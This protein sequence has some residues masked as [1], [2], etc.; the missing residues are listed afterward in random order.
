VRR[1]PVYLDLAVVLAALWLSPG[2][3]QAEP[4][5]EAKRGAKGEAATQGAVVKPLPLPGL[6]ALALPDAGDGSSPRLAKVGEGLA[7]AWIS[8][9]GTP[10]LSLATLPF[11]EVE[12]GWGEPQVVAASS[13]LLVNWADVA[14]IGE[15][16][17]GRTVVAWPEYH[18]DD[19]KAGYGLRVA[20]Q[21]DDGSFAPAWSPDDV[22]RGPESGFVGFIA[23]PAGLRMFW[24]DGRELVGHGHGG[25]G[26]GGG[27]MQLRSVLLDDDG[28]ALGGSAILDDRTCECCKLGVGLL[29]EQP[30]AAYRD[31]SAA[32]VRDIFVAGPG[33]A[34]TAVANDGWTIAGCP[35]N[36]PAVASD[37]A[38]AYVAWFTGADDRS[39]TWIARASTPTT[40]EAPTRFDLGLPAGRVD[41]L[42]LADGGAL[43]TWF[44]YDAEAP[45][46]ALLLTRRLG[47][48][49]QLGPAFAVAEVGAAR[50]WGFPRTAMVGDE[51]L[52]VVTDPTPASGRPRLQGLLGPLPKL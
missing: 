50:D 46:R 42:A 27:T 49:G 47:S 9:A 16:A 10:T 52:W 12:A 11:A 31:R 26:D 13:R 4:E 21:L 37:G 44:E 17:A 32:E 36:G 30:F 29:G 24:L 19:P 15:T 2:C 48:E 45:G 39:A 22:Q 35:V 51:A 25:H 41:L 40:F 20:A 1:R 18:E 6:R 8:Q 7:L 3:R 43:I 28:Q 34:P 38:R 23:T 5:G 33:L 14:A